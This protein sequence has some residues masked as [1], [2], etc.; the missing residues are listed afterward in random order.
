MILSFLS[1]KD[2]EYT[3]STEDGP[4]TNLKEITDEEETSNLRRRNFFIVRKR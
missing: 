3:T 4:E 1:D 2:Y